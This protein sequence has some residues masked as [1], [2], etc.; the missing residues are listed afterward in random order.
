MIIPKRVKFRKQFRGKR[1]GLATRGADL[2]F[3]EFG[4]QAL[5]SGWITS[6]Q[7]EAARKAVSHYTRRGGRVWM[8]IICDK[9]ISRKPAET[10]MG[11]G[12]GDVYEYVAV[13]KPGRV[14]L[15]IGG[16]AEAQARAALR[17]AGFKL[18]IETQVITRENEE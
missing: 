3:G 4:L 17:L 1:R 5:V 18:P 16:V 15:E 13:I 6:R 2:A 8:R 10:R 9:P 14:L 12:K 7:I 11:S